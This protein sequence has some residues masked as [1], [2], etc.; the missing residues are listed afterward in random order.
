[1]T[2]NHDAGY[3]S[4]EHRPPPPPPPPPSDRFTVSTTFRTGDAEAVARLTFGAEGA[5]GPLAAIGT[6]LDRITARPAAFALDDLVEVVATRDEHGVAHNLLAS[7]CSSLGHLPTADIDVR[8]IVLDLIGGNETARKAYLVEPAFQ[9][10]VEI[11]IGV[12][13]RVADV[14]LRAGIEPKMATHLIYHAAVACANFGGQEDLVAIAKMNGALFDGP[15]PNL[16]DVL[17]I[18]VPTDGLG[19]KWNSEY[20]QRTGD[21]PTGGSPAATN[22]TEE[23][24]S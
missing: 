7:Y 12:L 19:P 20:Q 10:G 1:M 11:T 14:L 23:N 8:R 16:A 24:P 2:V 9:H 18:D 22:P 13:S 3:D 5:A 21:T 15:G 6:A 17:P 4:R